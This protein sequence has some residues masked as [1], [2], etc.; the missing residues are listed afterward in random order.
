MHVIEVIPLVK[1]PPQV[2]QLLSYFFDRPLER[3]ALV[4]V[5]MGTRA[6]KAVVVSSASLEEQKAL[7][8]KSAF[9][10]KKLDKVLD[11][12]TVLG[13][14]QLSLALWLSRFYF[15]PLGTCLKTVLPPFFGKK[16][17]RLDWPSPAKI[18]EDR[19][20]NK[21]P[22]IILTRAKDAHSSI[23]KLLGQAKNQTVIITPELD[24]VSYFAGAFSEKKPVVV[25]GGLS[26]AVHYKAFSQ[27]ADGT[28]RLVIGT[29]AA[30]FSPFTDL[31][32]VI[33][34]DPLNEAYKSDM[35]PRLNVPDL[36][37]KVAKLHG[38]DIA[39]LTPSLNTEARHWLEKG[40]YE[41]RDELKAS[42]AEIRIADMAQ[43][44]RTGNFSIFSR[45]LQERMLKT[46]DGG[47]RILLYSAR[48][49]YSSMLLCRNCGALSLCEKC[50]I[51]MR[52]HRAGLSA[53]GS[54][55]L[56]VCYRCSAY[57]TAP[58]RC[59]NCHSAMLKPTG[60]AGS[61]K[62]REQI[63]QFLVRHGITADTFILD[64]DLIRGPEQEREL[65]SEIAKSARPVVI[66]T[67]MIF[68]HRYELGFD[69]VGVISA[70]AL[71][72]S[73]DFRTDE[74]FFYQ[75]DRLNDFSPDQ[76]VIQ[77]FDPEQRA[78]Q[79][80][81]PGRRQEFF[82]AELAARK[83]LQYPPFSR[84]VKLTFRHRVQATASHNARVAAERLKMAAGRLGLSDHVRLLGPSPSL[85]ARD[86]G[87]Y[88][89]NLIL[90]V[91]DDSNKA[92]AILKYLPSQWLIDVDPR[93]IV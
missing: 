18:A 91:L 77:T 93:S 67:S 76:M 79:A 20:E 62:I 43:E 27:I 25:H 29:R 16:K 78:I 1:L 4:Q 71:L 55:S 13:K 87:E 10:L 7:V 72:S 51:P 70:D 90:K 21:K 28:A 38:A 23:A 30:L 59:P 64:S 49:A 46:L 68:S 66:A 61:Q 19:P 83:A 24:T 60:F 2:P 8:K 50:E 84:L 80:L 6:V 26:A 74:R 12:S 81:A 92:E 45:A 57:R 14:T 11:E 82:G 37:Q 58:D 22:I 42:P 40:E 39:Y 86:K 44:L 53:G 65:L 35:S 31:G 85:I 17:Y 54:E 69:L 89:Y 75:T 52:V 73:S 88:A 34:D 9:Q 63:E 5:P 32:L 56:L 15:A 3:G 33:V 41:L 48:R 36:A 47:G